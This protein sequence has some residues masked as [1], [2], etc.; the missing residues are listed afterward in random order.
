MKSKE[1]ARL[2]SAEAAELFSIHSAN[3]LPEAKAVSALQLFILQFKR[4][5][6]Y[7]L[8]A[9]VI[10][11]EVSMLMICWIPG[12]SHFRPGSYGMEK[13]QTKWTIR[14]V[15]GKWIA[16]PYSRNVV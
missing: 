12:Q 2:S 16:H 5:F 8:I 11:K 4:Q 7:V 10:N 14:V 1:N 13:W 9:V 6:I 15:E 3:V